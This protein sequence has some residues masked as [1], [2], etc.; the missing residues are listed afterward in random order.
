MPKLYEYYQLKSKNKISYLTILNNE[1][2]F[3]DNEN[4][5]RKREMENRTE[6]GT[7]CF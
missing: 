2:N 1:Y 6:T 5:S 4:G 3:R 7:C